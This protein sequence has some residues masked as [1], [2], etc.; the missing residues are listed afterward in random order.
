MQGLTV[1]ATMTWLIDQIKRRKKVRKRERKRKREKEGGREGPRET[2]TR[3][4]S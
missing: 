1:C 2:E 3:D 4:W